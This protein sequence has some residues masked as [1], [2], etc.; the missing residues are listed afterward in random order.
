MN[1]Q[2][3]CDLLD[4]PHLGVLVRPPRDPGDRVVGNTRGSARLCPEAGA[5]VGEEGGDDLIEVHYESLK[6]EAIERN[7]RSRNIYDHH[8]FVPKF[9]PEP[10][11]QFQK[12]L[13]HLIGLES[14]NSWAKKHGLDQSTVQRWINGETDPKLSSVVALAQTLG[15]Q[16]GQLVSEHLVM[17]DL[18]EESLLVGL[19]H[20]HM[21]PL[22]RRRLRRLM[23]AATDAPREQRGLSDFADLEIP[24]ENPDDA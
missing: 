14:V 6:H 20:K 19:I 15:L 24:Q 23:D 11:T 4:R 1:L 18:D 7:A 8:V 21:T 17:V 16:P 9:K 3:G 2:S 22:E 13:L 10:E 12:N 5:L